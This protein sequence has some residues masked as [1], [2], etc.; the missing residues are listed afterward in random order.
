MFQTSFR[1]R[2][3]ILL[4]LLPCHH[5]SFQRISNYEH[6]NICIVR[7]PCHTLLEVVSSKIVNVDVCVCVCRFYEN[8]V[9][10]CLN[11]K[12]NGFGVG[13][14][15]WLFEEARVANYMRSTFP[16]MFWNGGDD[17]AV[18]KHISLRRRV[19]QRNV[20]PYMRKIF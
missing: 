14:L 10:L 4:P 12:L 17:G 13:D 8:R 16:S 18:S 3:S 6:I 2:K 19:S 9:R 7:L 15:C 20:F 1:L 5:L 11:C